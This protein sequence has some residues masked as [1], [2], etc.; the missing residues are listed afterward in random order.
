MIPIAVLG[1]SIV[2]QL[3]AAV[4]ALMLI[5][6]NTGMVAWSWISAA[7]GLMA[8]RRSITFYYAIVG[9]SA[10]SINLAAELVALVISILML[11]GIMLI[12]PR[13][14]AMQ[15]TESLL[16]E[17][18]ATYRGILDNMLDT[19]YRT[20]LDG[21]ITMT[22]GYV[23]TLLG[24]RK[25]ELI[26][27]PMSELYLD[28]TDRESFLL[29][30]EKNDGRVKNHRSYLQHKNGRRDYRRNQRALCAG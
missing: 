17:Q 16:R 12:R 13:L 3:S 25:K 4:L 27:M 1:I 23:E 6:R 20:D 8:T 10:Q 21:R 19:F 28:P 7:L 22:Y 9:D 11:I 14:E 18:E 24:Y 30:L 29:A 26:G 2:L 5:R 15:T